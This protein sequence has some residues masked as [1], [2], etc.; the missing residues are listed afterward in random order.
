MLDSSLVRNVRIDGVAV[1]EMVVPVVEPVPVRA[2]NR[3]SVDARC[4]RTSPDW[5][6]DDG[7]TG[8][9]KESFLGEGVL[10]LLAPGCDWGSDRENPIVGDGAR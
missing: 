3:V 5:V 4:R 10:R 8:A 9:P 7:S 6:V 2:E 1:D